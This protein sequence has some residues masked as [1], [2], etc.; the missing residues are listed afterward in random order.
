MQTYKG[1]IG[2]E[3][4]KLETHGN[5]LT[6]RRNVHSFQEENALM[7][8]NDEYNLLVKTT[9]YGMATCMTPALLPWEELILYN[10]PFNNV[11]FIINI[12]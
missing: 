1:T 12:T 11:K 2:K 5:Y 4:F 9:R 7:I 6:R 10:T 8:I 3:M